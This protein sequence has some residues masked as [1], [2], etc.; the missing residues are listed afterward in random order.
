MPSIRLVVVLT[1][2]RYLSGVYTTWEAMAR[3]AFARELP[4]FKGFYLL[5]APLA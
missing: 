2:G 1:D 3:L 5:E 4:L